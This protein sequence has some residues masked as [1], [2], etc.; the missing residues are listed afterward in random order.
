MVSEMV[1]LDDKDPETPFTV[2]GY[3]RDLALGLVL[4]V[5]TLLPLVGLGPK[6]AVTPF[7]SPEAESVT[8]ELNPF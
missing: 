7:G 4:N 1:V 2:M 8:L 6:A 3:V 5:K